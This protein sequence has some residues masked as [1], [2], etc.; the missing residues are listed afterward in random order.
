VGII[1]SLLFTAAYFRDD[2]KNRLVTNLLAIDERHR[3]LWGEAHQR[4]DLERIFAAGIDWAA[5]PMTVAETEFVD[6]AILH[7]ETGWRIEKIM[8]RGE[9]KLLAH[10]A[11]DFF[12]LPIPRAVWEKTK[13]F[14]NRRFVRFV[15]RALSESESL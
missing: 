9:M 11:G 15:E 8:N 2:S 3:S 1:E 10:D 6:S 14:R 4:K 13:I 7:F 12:S 5:Q